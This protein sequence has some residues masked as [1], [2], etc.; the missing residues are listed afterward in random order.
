MNQNQLK[1]QAAEAALKYIPKNGVLGVGTGST[2]NYFI[3]ALA[4]IKNQIEYAVASSVAT[5]KLLR[6]RNIPVADLNAVN[7]VDVYID[8]ADEANIYRYLIKGLGGAL[9]REKIIAT[10]AKKFVCI[11]DESKQVEILSRDAPV[12]VEVIPMARGYVSRQLV[13][14]GGTPVYREG[15]KTDNGNIILDVFNLKILDPVAMENSIKQL[16]GVIDSGIFAKRPADIL[17][18]ATQTGVNI[19]D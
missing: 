11:I 1:Q 6:E 14:L 17:L 15:A 19:I 3:D 12:P 8:G 2:V 10:V 9:T 7:N 13:Q 18:V 5:E 16:T 4:A